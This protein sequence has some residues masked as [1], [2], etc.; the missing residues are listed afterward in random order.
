MWWFHNA[1]GARGCVATG[2]MIPEVAGSF[3]VLNKHAEGAFSKR[4]CS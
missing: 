2:L 1:E 3:P 4:E